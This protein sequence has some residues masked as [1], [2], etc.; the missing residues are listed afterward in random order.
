MSILQPDKYRFYDSMGREV[1]SID[2]GRVYPDEDGE[3]E[4]YVENASMRSIADIA[5]KS[6]VDGLEIDGPKELFSGHKAPLTI[7]WKVGTDMLDADVS[8]Q[9]RMV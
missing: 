3:M 8:V 5:W 1:N 4:L 9:G 2:F 7:R 6:S